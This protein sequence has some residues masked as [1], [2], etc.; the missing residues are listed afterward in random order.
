MHL[1]FYDNFLLKTKGI[2]EVLPAELKDDCEVKLTTYGLE[3]FHGRAIRPPP[4]SAQSRRVNYVT[5]SYKSS[6]S[7]ILLFQLLSNR[8]KMMAGL[9]TIANALA[10]IAG[11]LL[12]LFMG[13]L[14]TKRFQ[15]IIS[16]SL[17][18]SIIAMSVS[19][20]VSKMLVIQDG[21]IQT[22]GTYLLI[23]SL[24]LGSICGEIIDVDRLTTRFG[25]WLKEKTGSS[26]DEQFVNGFVTA[27]FT[28][29]I[30]AM[31]IL[32][33]IMDGLH[34]DHSILFTKAILDFVI[35]F[36]MSATMGKGCIFSAIPVFLFQGAITIL[37]KLISPLLV[38]S[39]IEN[40]SL[41][42]SVL[43]LCI[44]INLLFDGKFRIKVANM[45][46]AIVF[47]VVGAYIPFLQ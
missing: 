24:V 43:I 21:A 31:A 9:G 27:S 8:E 20:F 26:K 4:G 44:G 35:I 25:G 11:G 13:K 5:H 39:T 16:V 41:V 40:I 18:L 1:F 47:A 42:G 33:A 17:A 36:V 32:G 37:A 14:L 3:L 6:S 38:D 23:F 45:L 22:R 34:A 46:P 12:G 10:I 19:G 7:K 2:I 29:C 28:V 30:G 15:D